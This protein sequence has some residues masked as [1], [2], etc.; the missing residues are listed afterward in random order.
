MSEVND[1]RSGLNMMGFNS[2]L[3]EWLTS[4]E[5]TVVH[6]LNEVRRATKLYGASQHETQAH[7]AEAYSPVRVT[8][9]A[10]KMGLIP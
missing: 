7:V 2:E 10:E 3:V 5:L 8:G 6:Q 4:G 9:M 1:I